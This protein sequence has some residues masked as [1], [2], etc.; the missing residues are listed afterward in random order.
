MF[1]A[2]DMIMYIGNGEVKNLYSIQNGAFT[3]QFTKGMVGRV[4]I[5]AAINDDIVCCSWQKYKGF[6]NIDIKDVCK[7]R[8][9]SNV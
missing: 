3:M 1:K 9:D 4:V 5:S 8:G 6:M 2:G 7:I